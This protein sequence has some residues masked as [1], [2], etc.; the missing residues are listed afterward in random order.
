MAFDFS[1]TLL[2]IV[3]R[4]LSISLYTVNFVLTFSYKEV[5]TGKSLKYDTVV[6]KEVS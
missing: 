2:I 3:S 1:A 6:S 5:T 4:L